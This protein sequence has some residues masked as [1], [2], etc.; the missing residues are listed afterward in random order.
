M[1]SHARN[2]PRF[3]FCC[4]GSPVYETYVGSVW[5]PPRHPSLSALFWSRC[6]CFHHQLHLIVQR[7]LTHAGRYEHYFGHLATVVNVWRSRAKAIRDRWASEFT[8]ERAAVVCKRLPHRPLKGRWCSCAHAES[9]LLQA[10]H[11]ET[12]VV[13][14]VALNT[15]STRAK[16]VSPGIV[17]LG[18]EGLEDTDAYTAR[19]G[20]WTRTSI[21]AVGT[22]EFW[23]DVFIKHHCRTPITTFHFWLSRDLKRTKPTG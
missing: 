3:I 18:L 12:S 8:E 7:Q 5:G 16:K 15:G 22:L 19:L 10:G 11:P 6:Y 23:Q 20:R 4:A 21:T 14:K 13:L 17:E 2:L 1:F 9:H